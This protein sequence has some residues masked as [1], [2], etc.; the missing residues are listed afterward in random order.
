[1]HYLLGRV[2]YEEYWNELGLTNKLNETF[3]YVKSTNVNRTIESVQS[4]LFGLFE[5]LD[6]WT[7]N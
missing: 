4:Q 6:P 2:M 5:K 3:I 7:L 1:M